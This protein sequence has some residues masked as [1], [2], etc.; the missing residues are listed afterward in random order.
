MVLKLKLVDDVIHNWERIKDFILAR[1]IRNI[2]FH[3]KIL[4]EFEKIENILTRKH[5]FHLKMTKLTGNEAKH[6]WKECFGSIIDGPS[7]F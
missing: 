3:A 7:T 4:I 6:F 5:S 1:D 2:P